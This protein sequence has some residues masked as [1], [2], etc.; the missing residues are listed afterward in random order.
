MPQLRLTTHL[1]QIPTT[2]LETWIDGLGNVARTMRLLIPSADAE[3]VAIPRAHVRT[4][5]RHVRALDASLK[6][7]EASS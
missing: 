1:L 7:F 6:T 2:Q 5:R 3:S 4:W